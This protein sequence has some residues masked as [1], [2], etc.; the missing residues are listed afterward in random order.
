MT[1]AKL[2]TLSEYIFSLATLTKGKIY[3]AFFLVSN[4]RFI[5]SISATRVLPA[6]VGAE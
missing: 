5:I 6:L 2:L 4:T 3:M 1:Y